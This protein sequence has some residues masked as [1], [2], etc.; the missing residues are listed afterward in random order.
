MTIGHCRLE[1]YVLLITTS[2][3]MPIMHRALERDT[4]WWRRCISEE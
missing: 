3:C 2:T 4:A 1:D